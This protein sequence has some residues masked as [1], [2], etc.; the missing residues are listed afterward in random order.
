MWNKHVDQ[1]KF[2]KNHLEFTHT[3]VQP[4]NIPLYRTVRRAIE[5]E[6]GEID[7]ML[8]MNGIKPAKL[9]SALPALFFKRKT[10]LSFLV[11]IAEY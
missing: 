4:S 3:D 9:D 6:I 5:S 10:Y 8:Q 2:A 7:K 11:S 1:I